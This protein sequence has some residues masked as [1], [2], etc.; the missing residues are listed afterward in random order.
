MPYYK[1]GAN[2][3]FNN[4]IKTHPKVEFLIYKK[5]VYY[6]REIADSGEFTSQVL[7]MAE[8]NVSLY[9]LNV[10]R[11]S[12]QLSYP[13]VTKNGTITAFRTVATTEFNQDFAYGD[14]ISGTYPL[15][16]SISRDYYALG[17]TR[18]HITALKNTLNYYKY[19]S[20]EYEFSNS[21]RDLSSVALNLISIP[22]I[23]YGSEIKK[24][25]V[26]LKF[27]VSGAIVGQA[28]DEKR[29]GEL[30]QTGPVGSAGSGS[31]VGVV[32][33][34]EGFILLTGSTA[35]ST[36]HSENYVPAGTD[37]PKWLHFATTGSTYDVQGSSFSIDFEGTNH[38]PTL[39]MLAHAPK[40]E[41]NHSNNITYLKNGETAKTPLTGSLTYR[42]QSEKEI[43]NIVS[44][45]FADPTGSFEKQ[46]YISKIGLYD[47]DKNLIG[48][49]KLATPVRKREIDSYTFKLKL[50]F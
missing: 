25:S 49:A 45:S 37:N 50:D 35:L 41:L 30:I 8:G 1:F 33:Y 9:E 15:T 29:N 21:A 11:P 4:T 10:D 24:G 13:F 32:L 22:S 47:K 40:G 5:K 12:G 46:V 43:K 36:G 23:F 28:K 6:N 48:I 39:T 26:N 27:H 44:S 2:D 17:S 20:Q 38:V 31:V 3:I 16:A 7:H 34:T 42:E 14:T 19:L 18:T